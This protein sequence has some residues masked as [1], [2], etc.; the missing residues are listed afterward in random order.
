MTIR[1]NFCGSELL[2]EQGKLI[3]IECEHI[4]P[5]NYKKKRDEEEK[6]IM[7]EFNKYMGG[8]NGNRN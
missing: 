5:E 3:C 1:C 8:Q 2:E 7:N 6:R 4:F